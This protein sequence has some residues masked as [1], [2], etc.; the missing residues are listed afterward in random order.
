MKQTV[1]FALI[2]CGRISVNHLDAIKNAPHA[3]L[4]AVCDIDVE[5]AEIVAKENNCSFYTDYITMLE[6][7]D[8]DVCSI[9]TPSGYH[10]EIGCEVAKR[11]VNVLCEKPIDVTR[12]KA[13]MLIKCCKDNKVKL[14]C[15]FQ[16]R[17][18]DAAIKTKEAVEKGLLGKVTLADAYLKYYRDDEYY[19]SGDWRGTLELDGGALMNQ[20]IHGIDMI[21]WI[22]GGIEAVDADC[23]TYAWNIEAEDTAVIRVKYKN[24]AMGV[25]EGTTTAYSGLETIFAVHGTD[26]S[27]IFGDK[28]F[29]MWDLKDK[30]IPV[31]DITNSMGGVNCQY[32][33]TNFGHTYLVE[34]MAMAVIEDRAPMIS[35]EEARKAVD[36]ILASCRSSEEKRELKVEY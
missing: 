34:D 5:K 15:I 25:I 16:R 1:N 35:G 26:G 9:L 31:P 27:I 2:G 8:I 11:G 14:G 22:M 24:G 20:S 29:Y 30:S 6:S 21:N 28:G 23:R 36:I 7:E 4:V 18:Y 10:A 32:N 12:E 19:A 13:D 17:T 3:K 33:E